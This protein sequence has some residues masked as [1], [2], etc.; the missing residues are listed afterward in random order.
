ML[1]LGRKKA[2]VLYCVLALMVPVSLIAGVA[3]DYLPVLALAAILPSVLLLP[4]P[5][6]WAFGAPESAVPI[7]A[8]GANVI[9][10]LTTNAVL[11]A[12]LFV[13]SVI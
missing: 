13:A 1:L 10:N 8:M 11:A 7:P 12:A 4:Q 3:L 5:F 2:A 6:R 9:W